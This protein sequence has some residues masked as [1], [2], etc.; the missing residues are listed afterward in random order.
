MLARFAA[1]S[2]CDSG[3]PQNGIFIRLS[4][5]SVSLDSSRYFWGWRQ[6]LMTEPRLPA[7]AVAERS[8]WSTW[9]STIYSG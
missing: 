3:G 6:R 4:A 5:S 1:H 9:S 2:G 7:K 8:D